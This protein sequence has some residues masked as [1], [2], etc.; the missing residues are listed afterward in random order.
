MAYPEPNKSNSVGAFWVAFRK[1]T[2]IYETE[3]IE[4]TRYRKTSKTQDTRNRDETRRKKR[5][6]RK[7]G[8][9]EDIRKEEERS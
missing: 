6:G 4:E 3:K 1:V 9:K 5:G 8:K 7:W 2:I